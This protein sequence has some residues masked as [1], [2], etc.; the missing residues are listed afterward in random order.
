M[1]QANGLGRRVRAETVMRLVLDGGLFLLLLLLPVK[2]GIPFIPSIQPILPFSA[3]D[4]CLL[5]WPNELVQVWIALL[6]YGWLIF[7]VFRGSLVWVSSPLNVPVLCYGLAFLL[8]CTATLD[9]FRTLQSAPLVLSYL[10]FYFLLMQ[11]HS[12]RR[13]R[14]CWTALG[15]GCALVTLYGLYQYYYGLA[16]TRAWVQA[17][18]DLSKYPQRFSGRLS[19]NRVFSTFVYPNSLGSYFLM[20]LPL[21]SILLVRGRERL[22]YYPGAAAAVALAV[23]SVFFGVAPNLLPRGVAASFL[24]PVLAWYVFALTGSQGAFASMAA[25]FAVVCG[26][27]APRVRW[28]L[29]AA[30]LLAAGALAVSPAARARVIKLPSLSARVQYWQAGFGMVLDHPLLGSGP[31]TF[32]ALYARYM[33]PGAEE[34]QMAHNH[35]LQTWAE[36]GT[37]TFVAFTFIWIT[38]LLRLLSKLTGPAPGGRREILG[39]ALGLLGF[40][41]HLFLDFDYVIPGLTLLAVTLMALGE[42]LP[43]NGRAPARERRIALGTPLSRCAAVVLVTVPFT[44]FVLLCAGQCSASY[45]LS[46]ANRNMNERQCDQ[47]ADK[48]I[49]AL[50]INPYLSPAYYFLGGMA[51]AA[52]HPDQALAFYLRALRI[53]PTISAY[54]FAAARTLLAD[55]GRAPSEGLR[56]LQLAVYHFPTSDQY[57]DA[58]REAAAH[59]GLEPR[60]R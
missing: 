47:A 49:R 35:Y 14:L 45:L 52:H 33:L 16:E 23:A 42:R 28:V 39:C 22:A 25:A 1:T 48:A 46:A 34:T 18:M 7:C 40:A 43:G 30:V 54:H 3:V 53:S 60:S 10:M 6:A 5:S 55:A 11:T 12:P 19:S 17:H 50:E 20:V 27:L 32:G 21:L 51:E 13:A 24:F 26:V 57:R 29:L 41:A 15:C 38:A 59:Y 31:G 36:S 4:W 44:W 56:K 8:S 37:L 9:V 58:L 2:F